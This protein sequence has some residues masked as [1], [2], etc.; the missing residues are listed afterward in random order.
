MKTV[1]K[2]A[3]GLK[4]TLFRGLHGDPDIFR[5][6]DDSDPDGF[7]DYDL[8]H[9]DLVIEISMDNVD[10][11]LYIRSSGTTCLDHSPEVLGLNASDFKD[12]R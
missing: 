12:E 6:Y 5:V 3:R 8:L 11:T 4:G 10:A 9:N 7:I 1:I 2:N